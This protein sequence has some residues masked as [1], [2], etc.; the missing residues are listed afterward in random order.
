MNTFGG[1]KVSFLATTKCRL[2]VNQLTGFS[3]SHS[4]PLSVNQTLHNLY[5]CCRN[6]KIDKT[7]TVKIRIIFLFTTITWNCSAFRNAR[8][9]ACVS[10]S[11]T[12]S[13][14]KRMR[15][16]LSKESRRSFQ[17]RNYHFSVS[18]LALAFLVALGMINRPE[19]QRRPS[20]LYFNV[21]SLKNYKDEMKMLMP[22]NN[23]CWHGSLF[24]FRSGTF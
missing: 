3:S 14:S 12:I 2:G 18:T 19:V 17:E 8:P 10:L 22:Y 20:I 4:P 16:D 7:Q 5:C 1:V 6:L 15:V 13:S 21:S 11:N 24:N 23:S 9:A